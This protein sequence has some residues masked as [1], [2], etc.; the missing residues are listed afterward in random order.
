M[1]HDLLKVNQLLTKADFKPKIPRFQIPFC[2]NMVSPPSL[3]CL[4]E[5]LRDGDVSLGLEKRTRVT[6]GE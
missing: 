1:L 6:T 3:P 4:S 2:F 5:A